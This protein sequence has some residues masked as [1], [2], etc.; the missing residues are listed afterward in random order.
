MPRRPILLAILSLVSLLGIA[1][2]LGWRHINP[3]GTAIAVDAQ[4]A[5]TPTAGSPTPAEPA[6]RD[7]VDLAARTGNRALAEGERQ[8]QA[9]QAQVLAE[10]VII[11]VNGADVVHV[12]DE[13]AAEAVRDQ[14]LATYKE[15]VLQDAFAIE[16]LAFQETIAWRRQAVPP[17]SIR[18][19]EEAINILRLGTDK[20][21]THTVQE[22]DTSWDIA[23]EYDLTTDQLAQAN[24]G[25]DLELLQIG[26]PLTITAKEPYVHT[27]SV[28]Q[29]VEEQGIPFPEE[30]IEDSNLWPWQYE[31]VTPGR[32]GLRRLTLREHHEDGRLVDTEVL[33]NEVLEQPVAQ[34]SKRGTKQVPP[35]GSGSLVYPVVGQLSSEFGPR[36]GSWHNAIDIAAPYGTPIL[37]A[38]SGMVTFAAWSGN[39]G[40]M[41]KIDHGGAEM[42]TLYA[43]LSAFNV[44][45]GQTVSK[46]DVIGYVGSTGY[47]TGPHL[48][49]E[50]HLDGTP[51]NPLNFYQ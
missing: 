38:D 48:H 6:Q 42:E 2:D 40:Y 7:R 43:H 15:T 20:L 49:F 17:E 51:V 14:I 23:I 19:V 30:V 44:S 25:V 3:P 46:G 26:Q 31:V 37:A 12:A 18:S 13:A 28:S 32:W 8:P 41:I 10:A 5:E 4:G 33:E 50:V 16:E 11:T 39:Y 36:W 24:P 29:R 21:I 45:V 22:G 9:T 1:A 27:R 47:S 35:M 34:V